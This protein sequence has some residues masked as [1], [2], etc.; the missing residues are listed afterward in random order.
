MSLRI[1]GIAAFR[2][3]P[4]VPVVMQ[5][6]SRCRSGYADVKQTFIS[7]YILAEL[8]QKEMKGKE[9]LTNVT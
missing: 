7:L 6:L 1:T 2:L 3:D 8:N 4:V 5:M 9:N